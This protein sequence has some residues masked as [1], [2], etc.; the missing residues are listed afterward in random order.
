MTMLHQE[1]T[2][3]G[4]ARG[5]DGGQSPLLHP[6]ARPF[7]S[8]VDDR[9]VPRPS[10][11]GIQRSRTASSTWMPYAALRASAGC[12]CSTTRPGG[13]E[14]VARDFIHPKDAAG[15]LVELVEPATSHGPLTT[16]GSDYR[17]GVTSM[18]E[19]LRHAM[20]SHD[21]RRLASLF[22][23]DYQ[24]AQPAA[25]G[26]GVRWA[27]AGAREL[28]VGL[29]RRARLHLG[30]GRVRRRTETPSGASGTGT[31]TTRTAHRS[32]CAGSRS[33]SCVTA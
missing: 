32:R 14:R 1:T 17:R 22:A 24:S 11:P 2:R 30:T 6:A 25:P 16:L 12:A 31:A 3:A 20:N 21:A 15:I 7:F 23:E 18:L 27:R 13:H 26:S 10:G 4:R 28:V 5:D 8:R 29:R 19:R 33:W 9:E